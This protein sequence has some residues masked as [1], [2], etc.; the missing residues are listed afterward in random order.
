MLEQYFSDARIINQI[1]KE[2]VKQAVK[3]HDRQNIGRLVG[4]SNEPAPRHPFYNLMPPRRQ[5]SAFRP[6][7]RIDGL[8]P[9][10]YALKKAVR[11]LRHQNPELPWV[12]ELNRYIRSIRERVFHSPSF[13]ISPPRINYVLKKRGGQEYR[14][15]CQ[16]G[17]DDNLILCLFANYLRE[18]YDPMFSTSS[19]AFRAA[20]NGQVTTHHDAF[21][22]I[23]NLK[24]NSG[25]RSLYVAECDIR[26]FFDTVDHSLALSAF[27]EAA[28]RVS[29]HPRAE[30]LFQAYLDCYSFPNNVL[31]EAEP[32]LRQSDPNG[33]FKWP[34]PQLRAMHNTDPR[35]LRIGVSQGGAVSGII[36]NLIMDRAD[37]CVEAEG[38]RLGADIHYY[39]FCDDMVLIS[40]NLK[41]CKAVFG[42]YLN[43]LTELKLAYHEPEETCIYGKQHWKHKSKA[44]YLWS[45]QKWFGCVPWVQFVGY[46]IRYDGLVRPRKEA[47]AKQCMKLVETTNMLKYGLLQAMQRNPVQASQNQVLSSLKSKLVAQGVGRVK[48]YA[49]GPRPMCWASGYRALHNKPIVDHALRSFD[50]ARKKQLRRFAAADIMYG[51]GITRGNNQNRPDP[52]GYAYSYHAQFTNLG[53]DFLIHNPWRPHNLLDAAKQFVFLLLT[54][55]LPK[56]F[57]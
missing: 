2:R 44:P 14:A 45:G 54:R 17:V 39:R 13:A 27:R 8:N 24:H 30:V 43:K 15:L 18:K 55:R 53:G 42:A 31:A 20:L 1:C 36:A 40:P 33:H 48:G 5:W 26:G 32:R 19:F 28:Q 25:N 10:L 51:T 41:H 35:G 3:Q 57:L 6:R 50:K 56:W 9:D 34:E 29:L 12:I 37:K 52:E 22:E 49:N 4:C 47:V 23:Y 11:I 46:Q 38:A 21:T 7:Y 16:Y